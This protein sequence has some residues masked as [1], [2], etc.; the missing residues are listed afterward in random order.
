MNIEVYEFDLQR[1][2][3]PG[4]GT[5]GFLT[6]FFTSGRQKLFVC[7]A[8]CWTREFAAVF[9][10]IDD[11]PAM[12]SE[13]IAYRVEARTSYPVPAGYLMLPATERLEVGD[14]IWNSDKQAFEY[15]TP[16]II[17][18]FASSFI[19]AIRSTADLHKLSDNEAALIDADIRDLDE[20]AD[21]FAYPYGPGSEAKAEFDK[22]EQSGG[23]FCK[24]CISGEPGKHDSIC[25][26]GAAERRQ[27]LADNKPAWAR[28]STAHPGHVITDEFY[29]AMQAVV[30]A[31][32]IEGRSPEYHNRAKAELGRNWR[33][34]FNAISKLVDASGRTK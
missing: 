15:V 33:T 30:D 22:T 26:V 10:P 4:C 34:L 28:K 14:K 29:S 9:G 8:D 13:K 17:G 31:W 20:K 6:V 16:G 3:C 21:T 27:N 19:C 32:I 24:G 12:Q 25:P 7:D 18:K 2:I 11:G 5:E 23:I 1:G